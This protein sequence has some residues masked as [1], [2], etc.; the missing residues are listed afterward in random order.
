MNIKQEDIDMPK[1]CVCLSSLF[2][3]LTFI[4]FMMNHKKDINCVV[5]E[6]ASYICNILLIAVVL[7]VEVQKMQTWTLVSRLCFTFFSPWAC[8]HKAQILFLVEI[9]FSAL[10]CTH[11]HLEDAEHSISQICWAHL[12]I[13]YQAQGR[14]RVI[15]SALWESNGRP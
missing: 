7:V 3:G 15:Y 13:Q 4:P 6:W 14:G 9:P 1:A 12:G 10:R 2:L 11:S 5:A 8:V